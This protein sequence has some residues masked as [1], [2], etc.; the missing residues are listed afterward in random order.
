MSIFHCMG[1]WQGKTVGLDLVVGSLLKYSSGV[2]GELRGLEYLHKHYGILPWAHIMK[3]AI[4]VARNGF[5]VTQ[6][7]VNQ[8]KSATAGQD[9]FLVD[10]PS[11][12]IDFAPNGI[13]LGLNET[14]TRKR[15]ADTLETISRHGADAFYTG[16]IANATIQALKAANGT[17]TLNDLKNYAVAIRKPAQIDYRGYKLTACSAPSSGTVA[18]SVMKTVEGYGDFGQASALNISTHRLDEAIRFA[19]GEVSL[20]WA[21]PLARYRIC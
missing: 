8:E 7:L 18:M 3:P 4:D 13:L 11:F 1:A 17:M 5:K 20:S 19:Y 14:I 21:S 2:P 16:P 15:Y 10:N 6:D 9:N 12:A